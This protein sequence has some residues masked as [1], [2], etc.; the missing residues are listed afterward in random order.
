M[1]RRDAT[2]VLLLLDRLPRLEPR[3]SGASSFL[4]LSDCVCLNPF[5]VRHKTQTL[6][7]VELAGAEGCRV[8][9]GRGLEVHGCGWVSRRR[10]RG[11]KAISVS[12]GRGGG[13]AAP[14]SVCACLP[15][16]LPVALLCNGEALLPGRCDA[17]VRSASC[18]RAAA[19]RR[20]FASVSNHPCLHPKV[21]P[22]CVCELQCV[23]VCVTVTSTL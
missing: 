7:I 13:G 6:S 20:P 1:C 23:C 21:L 4:F 9:E 11:V 15:P 19:A 18:M 14:V 2:L 17:T 12:G 5:P 3:G 8:G 16:P 22:V 10:T